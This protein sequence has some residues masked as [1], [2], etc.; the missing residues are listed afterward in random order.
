[1]KWFQH[2]TD[3]IT[4]K[5]LME[6]AAK[7]GAEGVGVYW[8]VVEKIAAKMGTS[9]TLELEEDT[10]QI[11]HAFWGRTP[12]DRID[13][14]LKTCEDLA[15]F[16]RGPHGRIRCLTLLK[17]L[18]KFTTNNKTFQRMKDEMDRFKRDCPPTGQSVVLPTDKQ[19]NN[20]D[21]PARKYPSAQELFELERLKGDKAG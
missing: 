9:V 20:T 19:T 4:D 15:L 3:A 8:T 13:A 17:K 5:K 12:T 6:L 11:A 16:D 14:I 1:M 2:D 18:D 7:Y 10:Y 21:L